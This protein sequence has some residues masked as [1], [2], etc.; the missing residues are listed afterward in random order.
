MDSQQLMACATFGIAL[1]GVVGNAV[2]FYMFSRPSMRCSSVN[3]LL[4][5]LSLVDLSLLILAIPV[6][7]LPVLDVWESRETHVEYLA[8]MLKFV[9]PVNLM[10]QTCSIYIMVLITVERWTA[11]CR[12]LQVRIW[13]TPR[14][15]KTALLLIGFFAVLYNL[16][17][18]N[19]YDITT[20][21]KGEVYYQRNLRDIAQHPYYMIGYF[22]ISYLLTHFLIPFGAI[23]VLNGH[24]CLSIFHFRR[25]RQAM[26]RQQQ[27][28]HKTTVMLLMVTVM[29]AVC[30]T[31]PFLLN[32]VECAKPDLFIAESTAAIAFQL[33]DIST[34]LVVLNSAS[35]FAIYFMFSAKYRNTLIFWFRH[36][37]TGKHNDAY[38]NNL[39][40][41]R[42]QSM[43]N[44]SPSIFMKGLSVPSEVLKQKR[45]TISVARE[46]ELFLKPLYMTKRN[47]RAASEYNGRTKRSAERPAE[48]LL[49]P[50]SPKTKL[51]TRSLI[52]LPPAPIV[53]CDTPSTEDVSIT[54]LYQTL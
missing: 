38:Y 53:S 10:M 47:E 25:E 54:C 51:P 28:E 44:N 31:L 49:P 3:I 4:S 22:T 30:N 1:I 6:F 9:Y 21:E 36:G 2:S 14:K 29:F 13:C 34:L 23:I 33:N 16:I 42:T 18:F 43:R 45:N 24:V 15:S 35:T 41:S 40:L 12:P 7:V 26:T 27:R 50:R 52:S 20:T 37:C 17:R 5:A 8:Y 11:V 39:I 32:L 48:A 19:E 46:T